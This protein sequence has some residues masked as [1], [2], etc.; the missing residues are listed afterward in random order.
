MHSR[1]TGKTVTRPINPAWTD[2]CTE[3]R[4]ANREAFRDFQQGQIT[5]QEYN[6]PC[7]HT[8]QTANTLTKLHLNT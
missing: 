7:K 3:A 2:K 5:K 1:T 8:K 4:R 6:R